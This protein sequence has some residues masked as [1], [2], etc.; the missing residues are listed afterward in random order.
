M[1]ALLGTLAGGGLLTLL[2]LG[3]FGAAFALVGGA[4]R[5]RALRTG[6][7]IAAVA[8]AILSLDAGFRAQMGQSLVA[9]FWLALAAV[10]ILGYVVLLRRLRRRAQPEEAPQPAGLRLIEDDAA[11]TAD[12][13][14]AIRA[15]SAAQPGFERESF[16]VAWKD[17]TGTVRGAVQ[18][19]RVMELA[20]L[21]TLHVD[22]DWRGRGLARDLLQGAEYEARARGA[23]HARL[24]TY[25][26]QAPGLYEKLGWREVARFPAGSG[27]HRIEYEKAL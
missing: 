22:P 14:A 13:L 23:R 27:T 18:V 16:S 8:A 3:G 12:S 24:G 10:P 15:E 21:R 9:A 26:W 11:L 20:E 25:S 2:L 5:R 7:M 1:S 4:D 17:E 19:I 6:L